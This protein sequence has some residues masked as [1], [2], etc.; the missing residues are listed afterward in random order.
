MEEDGTTIEVSDVA[1]GIDH[2]LL[3]TLWQLMGLTRVG[4][5]KEVI[6]LEPTAI[7]KIQYTELFQTE[8]GRRLRLIKGQGYMD[9]EK[10]PFVRLRNSRLL[11][12][13]PDKELKPKELRL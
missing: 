7:V 6:W 3:K 8:G 9:M 11:G 2:T 13:R 1:S 12:F 5:D 4:E 10:R